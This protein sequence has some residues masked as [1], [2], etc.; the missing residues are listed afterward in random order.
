VVYAFFVEPAAI[1]HESAD[2]HGRH[3][4]GKGVL[5]MSHFVFT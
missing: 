3:C 5:A 4:H 1:K 2:S